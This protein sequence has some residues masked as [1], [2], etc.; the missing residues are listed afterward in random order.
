M[1]QLYLSQNFPPTFYE[2]LDDTVLTISDLPDGIWFWTV[3]AI[4]PLF[5]VPATEVYEFQVFSSSPPC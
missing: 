1:Y 2:Q 3:E 4:T 5:T